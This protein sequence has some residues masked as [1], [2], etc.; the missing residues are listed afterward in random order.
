MG[1]KIP[2]EIE[3]VDIEREDGSLGPGVEATCTNCG[4]QTHSFGES[5]ASI[6]RCL[7]QM[8]EQCPEGQS[9]FYVNAEDEE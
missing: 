9:N 3:G 8:R 5:D 1:R 2:C 4:H 6:R 7:A